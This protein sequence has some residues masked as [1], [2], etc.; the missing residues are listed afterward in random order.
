MAVA[1]GSDPWNWS[2]AEVQQFFRQD[3]VRYIADRASGQLPPLSTFAQ[4]MID[5]DV[6]GASL[7]DNVDNNALRQEFGV[8]SFR[9]RGSIMH[10]I[11][12]LQKR[13]QAFNSRHASPMP[14]TPWSLVATPHLRTATASSSNVLA[15]TEAVGENVRAGEVQVEDERGRKR[16]RLGFTKV[17]TD[18]KPSEDVTSY[19]PDA[20]VPVDELFYGH[21]KSGHVIDELA[22]DGTVLVDQHNP[23]TTE[24]N[25]QFSTH[26]KRP[27]K[28]EFVYSRVRHFFTNAEHV[29]VRRRGREALAI[30][31]YPEGKQIKARSAT[32][33]QA[34]K[35]DED[36]YIAI[37][38]QA[39]LLQS[40]LDYSGV[41]DVEHESTR[42]WEFLLQSHKQKEGE[43]Q[44]SINGTSEHDD[45]DD[46]TSVTGATGDGKEPEAEE[47]DDELALTKARVADLIDEYK[48][49]CIAKWQEKLPRLEEKQAWSV[50]KKTKKSRTVRDQ[51]IATARARINSATR[52]IN[53][54]RDDLLRVEWTNSQELR[55]SCGSFEVSVED[56]EMKRWEISVW[57]RKKE[58]AHI[59]HHG[60]KHAAQAVLQTPATGNVVPTGFVVHPND[61]MS[62]S[63]TPA[64]HFHANDS[65]VDDAG[66]KK[67]NA[68]GEAAAD[69]NGEEWH[70]PDG[71][72]IMT[73]AADLDS[74]DASDEMSLVHDETEPEPKPMSDIPEAEGLLDNFTSSPPSRSTQDRSSSKQ[75]VRSN[76]TLTGDDGLSDEHSDCPICSLPLIGDERARTTH[77]EEC[78]SKQTAE[79][80][81]S[82]SEDELPPPSSFIPR[83]IKHS[84]RT[85]A[86]SRQSGLSTQ[87]IELSSDTSPASTKGKAKAKQKKTKEPVFS[88]NPEDATGAEVDSWSWNSL[89]KNDDRI[90]ILIKLLRDA[91]PELQQ[92]LHQCLLGLGTMKERENQLRAAIRTHAKAGARDPSLKP[93]SAETMLQCALLATAWW[94]SNPAYFLEPEDQPDL[95]WHRL[96]DDT[97]G[98]IPMLIN[99]LMVILQKKG[100]K[101]L[102]GPKVRQSD[103]SIAISD[104]DD[105]IHGK[106]HKR[107][108]R[109][110]QISQLGKRSRSTALARHEQFTQMVESQMTNSSQLEAMLPGNASNSEVAINLLKKDDHE[111]IYIHP[112]I[113]KKMKQHQI[114]GVRFL[115]Y[116][117]TA[118][119]E[120]DDDD[121]SAQG[122]LLA[123]TMGLGK[124][125]Q[126]ISLLVAV[127]EASQSE[128]P[129]VYR[130]LPPHLRPK[131]VRGKRQLRMLIMC[132][133]SLI[134][135]WRRE[136]EQWSYKALG[137]IFVVESGSKPQQLQQLQDWHKYGGVLLIGYTLFRNFVSRKGDKAKVSN[138][139][140]LEE[141]LCDGP[142]IV[143]ADEAHSLKN[144]M[145][146]TSKA[147][148]MVKTE[149]RI[150]LTGTPMSNDVQEIYAL[151]SWV[152]PGYFGERA[153]FRAN[154]AE[155]IEKGTFK[156]ST[157][158]EKRK[159]IM[160]LKVLHKQIEPKVNRADITVLRG[161]IKPKVEFVLTVPLTDIQDTIYR[162]YVVA[163]RGGDSSDAEQANTRIFSWLGILGLLTNHPSAFRTKLL[164]PSTPKKGRKVSAIARE[165]TPNPSDDG[166][167]AIEVDNAVEKAVRVDEQDVYSLGF[168][169]AI[170]L[171]I[172]RGVTDDT[173]PQLSAK[174]TIFLQ[175][176]KLS[177]QCND[178][179]LVFSSSIPTLQYLSD[180]LARHGIGY[181]RI[182]GSVTI[183]KRPGVLEDF[184]RDKFDVM[185]VS[186]H[187]GGV[188][189]NIQ[190]ANRVIIMD[191][192]FNPTWEE[193]AIG[194]AYRLGQT[195]PV[196]VYRLLAGGTFETNM[197]NKQMFKTSLTQR[198]V[199]KRNPRRNAQKD[200]REFLHDPRAM[201]QEDLSQWM[202]KDPKVLDQILKQLGATGSGGDN[203]T[204]RAIET[205]ETL[206]E[207]V[208]DEPLNEEETKEVNQEI[209][210]ERQKKR[211]RKAGAQGG[212]GA[213]GAVLPG[214][215]SAST[216]AVRTQ[217]AHRRASS[218]AASA[219]K[220]PST[221]PMPDVN[222]QS[223]IGG[224]P[225]HKP[226]APMQQQWHGH[227]G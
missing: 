51:L 209:E 159:S 111:F 64:M 193:Q 68:E 174:A 71:S 139:A 148:N 163:L 4:T 23:D 95:P 29:S 14:Q 74:F 171:E 212:H 87:P 61:R 185:L 54:V 69:K 8:S 207:E 210:A 10:C 21:T 141:L 26:D 25:F 106:S 78:L 131:G 34:G 118:M 91:G 180:L 89:K 84:P 35:D 196:F 175:V 221:A 136:I 19:L 63:P 112:R 192:G 104:S 135:N 181:G 125:M 138:G 133:P 115:W 164:T 227:P 169:E 217:A 59:I 52:Q 36:E 126:A 41:E 113:A 76:D 208:L 179:V 17:S 121:D 116:Q 127:A 86:K 170:V 22:A 195:K 117:V 66:A 5:N 150:A 88:G 38:E 50:W 53:N 33:I 161:S 134:P 96:Y 153:E 57:Q 142:E 100:S 211:G 99:R 56:R 85:P 11:R 137:N 165:D 154:F 182:D 62:V 49:R 81:E 12:K 149:A 202:G 213:R 39:S 178:K 28:V 72:P 43:K 114:T 146:E 156:D 32:V 3:A 203:P 44:I 189:L 215:P 132:P 157:A 140:R 219:F 184:H 107:R 97:T 6:D 15:S 102:S 77:V 37:R 151:V 201:R 94:Q 128:D 40:G 187:A 183:A 9:Q 2:P 55:R 191:F 222:P 176:V 103:D 158:W 119:D 124:T 1:M 123:H 220:A 197:W 92:E 144:S 218:Q 172:L 122:C 45:D 27:G 18:T 75:P 98:Q 30:L 216:Q 145:S 214:Q 79:E 46:Q 168:T 190:G 205:T 101:L 60:V 65:A 31:P 147:A 155:P 200:M 80:G 167:T 199:D 7:L 67:V 70:T 82:D 105:N 42:E 83:K 188:G 186:T 120:D 47:S 226:S 20:A 16:R 58:P 108:K 93:D 160:K 109:K 223:F 110:V 225:F 177:R 198:V 206:Q 166:S 48:Q 73:P 129:R 162:R 90:R 204:I 13:S 152:A 24:H 194:R 143:I 224:L 173:D 130:Q